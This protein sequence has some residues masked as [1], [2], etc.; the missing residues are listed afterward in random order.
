MLMFVDIVLALASA[1]SAFALLPRHSQREAIR[2]LT[3]ASSSGR[4][5]PRKEAQSIRHGTD[6]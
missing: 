4:D 2:A 1:V 5:M 6:L 3:Q